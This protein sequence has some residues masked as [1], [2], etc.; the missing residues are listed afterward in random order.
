MNIDLLSMSG[1]KLYAPKGV[2]ALFIDKMN[3]KIKLNPLIHG[4][5]Q[6]SGFRSGTLSVHNIVG[7]GE[8]C[9]IALENIFRAGIGQYKSLI[10][11]SAPPGALT[12]LI[13]F[14][15]LIFFFISIREKN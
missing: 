3:N 15:T 4:G 8:A 13:G 9:S 7:F 10:I 5:G 2:G 14:V 11:D 12:P 1:H 6:E